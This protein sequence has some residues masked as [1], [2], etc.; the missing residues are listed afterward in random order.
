MKTS[1]DRFLNRNFALALGAWALV[2]GCASSAE[3]TLD[4]DETASSTS[5]PIIGGQNAV[6][7]QHK[8][9]AN[10]LVNDGGVWRHQCGGALIAAQW[11]LTAAHCIANSGGWYS[12]TQIRVRLGDYDQTVSE[13]S[14]QLK[15]V[16]T[17]WIRDGYNADPNVSPS[18]YDMALIKLSSA[19]TLNSNVN[20]I[21]LATQTPP[22]SCPP[23][24]LSCND[25]IAAGWGATAPLNPPPPTE[26]S[27]ILQR[28]TIKLRSQ[29]TCNGAEVGAIRS[30]TGSPGLKFDELCVGSSNGNPGPCKGDSGGP[31]VRAKSG[32]G[33]ELVGVSSWGPLYCTSYAVYGSVPAHTDWIQWVLTH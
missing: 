33:Y 24:N 20:T 11:V 12:N 26:S 3:E 10:V 1:F 8:W 32:G 17:V 9:I 27:N 15:N 14:E 28:A 21:A 22:T 5:A 16:T 31:L 23:S 6:A 2:T 19:A 18:N 29:S 13:A 7:G 25:V 4:R 30:A